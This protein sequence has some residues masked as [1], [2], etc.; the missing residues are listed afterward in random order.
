VNRRDFVTSAT[1]AA[2]ILPLGSTRLFAANP[3]RGD[4]LI[5]DAM[6]ELRTIYDANLLQ[7]ML[8]SGMDSITITLCDPKPVGAEALEL[9]VDSLLE[10]DRYIA[11]NPAQLLKAT[12]VVDIDA[13]RASGRLAVFYLYQ[14]MVQFGADLD[15]VDMFYA[16]GLR[17]C[18]LTYNERNLAGVGC[19]E[20]GDN[21]GLTDF[22]R[23]LIDRMNGRGM[24][25]DLS[26]ANM[27]TMLD[28]IEHSAAPVH[29]SHT[30]C[31]DLYPHARNTSDRN[32][33]ALADRGGVVGICQLRPFLTASKTG[34]LNT[35][36]D[37]IDHA[38]NVAGVEAVCIGSDRDH[39]VIEMSDE[40]LAELRSEEGSQV[41]NQELPYF[42]DEL[43]GPGRMTVVWEGLVERGY[44]SADVERIMGTNLR[45]LYAAVIG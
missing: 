43:N 14:N 30:G 36:F 32:L 17:S 23:E 5:M 26:H 18:Q 35:Y 41:V 44:A 1:A 20:E 13:A 45:R 6:G 11:A 12:S 4:T 16:M 9:A 21:G 19:R 25:V 28:A 8:D 31:N 33:R 38:V 15:R 37:H 2:T 7:Q 34:N 29:V 40:Y 39:R 42:I 22:G 27:P 10:Y 24:I 3:Q